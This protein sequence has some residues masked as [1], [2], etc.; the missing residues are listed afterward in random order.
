MARI[1]E[2][3]RLHMKVIEET[4]STS[5]FF[6]GHTFTAADVTMAFPFTTLQQFHPLGRSPCPAL[7]AD[8]KRIEARPAYA[9]A[10]KL[11]GPVRKAV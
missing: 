3:T 4:L 5:P 6:A 9:K 11:S 2:T 10:M 1:C 8:L 7:Q